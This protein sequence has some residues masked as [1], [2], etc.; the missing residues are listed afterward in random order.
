MQPESFWCVLEALL[1][2]SVGVIRKELS[3]LTIGMGKSIAN[4]YRQSEINGHKG[5]VLYDFQL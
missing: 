2:H 5:S 4:G 3:N 1:C